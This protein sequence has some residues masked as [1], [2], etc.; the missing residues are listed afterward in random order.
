MILRYFGQHKLA[1][2]VAVVPVFY[3]KRQPPELHLDSLLVESLDH[4]FYGRPGKRRLARLPVA[5]VVEPAVVEGGPM[6]SK[7]LQLGN[8]VEHLFWRDSKLVAP[9]APAYGVVFI[10]VDRSREP[11][12]FNRV[13][14]KMQRLVEIAGID[15]EKCARRRIHVA[16]LEKGFGR[17]RHFGFDT[18]LAGGFDRDRK[19]QGQ[20]FD[21]ADRL[22]NTV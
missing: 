17:N 5:V 22:S 14:P 8:R 10:I 9:A 6:N 1:P 15:G 20:G 2:A 19:R 12:F 16:R 13:R 18:A 3:P 11:F 21:M 4:V 7:L